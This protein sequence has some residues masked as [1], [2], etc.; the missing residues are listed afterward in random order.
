[1]KAKKD[2]SVISLSLTKHYLHSSSSMKA[3]TQGTGIAGKPAPAQHCGPAVTLPM[4][5]A[6]I[7]LVLSRPC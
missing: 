6:F 4:P 5:R 1:M 3:M 7:Q 2:L